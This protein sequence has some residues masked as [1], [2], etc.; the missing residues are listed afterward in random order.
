MDL[1]SVLNWWRSQSLIT[2]D[3]YLTVLENF[4]IL[5][6]CNSNN[7]EGDNLSYHTT[8]E[9]FEESPISA[10]GVLP[11]QVFEVRNQ[12][13]AFSFLIKSLLEK[14]S[15]SVEFILK[16]H[17]IM[18]YGSYDEIRWRKGERPGMFKINDYCV[19][20]TEEGTPP[21]YVEEDLLGLIDEINSEQGDIITIAAYFHASFETIHPFAD[22]NGRV[23]RTLLNYYLMLN[24]YPPMVIHNEDKNTYFMGLEVFD[25]TGDLSGLKLF[26]KE[27]LYKTWCKRISTADSRKLKWCRENA[28]SALRDLSDNELLEMMGQAY[29][30]FGN[31]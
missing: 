7:I 19:G 4:Q 12:K 2:E 30:K 15:I 3:D 28:P 31:R 13:F 17:K 20:I 11:R 10:P 23:G 1:E 25:R 16:L 14:V 18:L 22:G 5:F 9:I 24:G 27:Q 21:Q 29:E 26:F 6:T 8:R